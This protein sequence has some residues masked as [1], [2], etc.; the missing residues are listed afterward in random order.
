MHTPC[1]RIHPSWS[2]VAD[3]HLL[4]MVLGQL[5]INAIHELCVIMAGQVHEALGVDLTKRVPAQSGLPSHVPKPRI[6]ALVGSGQLL[7]SFLRLSDIVPLFGYFDHVDRATFAQGGVLPGANGK[8]RLRWDATSTL[9]CADDDGL[10]IGK[11]WVF[12][13][14]DRSYLLCNLQFRCDE[15]EMGGKVPGFLDKFPHWCVTHIPRDE[16]P[17]CGLIS[18]KSYAGKMELGV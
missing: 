14:E 18:K 5:L 13:N 17:R 15:L 1:T 9:G 4:V 12:R 16:K 11:F 10:A 7:R 8:V 3:T 2:P 6:R